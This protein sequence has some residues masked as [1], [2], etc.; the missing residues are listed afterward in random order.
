MDCWKAQMA[1][2]RQSR[3]YVEQTAVDYPREPVVGGPLHA[4]GPHV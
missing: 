3:F 1:A 2:R 4:G